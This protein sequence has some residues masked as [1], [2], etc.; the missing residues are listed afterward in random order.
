ML[1]GGIYYSLFVI[2]YVTTQQ[3]SQCQNISILLQGK[4]THGYSHPLKLLVT[5]QQLDFLCEYY[6]YVF[7]V[8]LRRERLQLFY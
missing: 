5:S 6:G 1:K 2:L 3:I 7:D 8:Y 4:E